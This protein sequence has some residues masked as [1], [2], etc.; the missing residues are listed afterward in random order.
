MVRIFE[1]QNKSEENQLIALIL[2][3]LQ[4]EQNI[5][6]KSIYMEIQEH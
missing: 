5:L 2:I 4:V 3:Y 1:I 6:I